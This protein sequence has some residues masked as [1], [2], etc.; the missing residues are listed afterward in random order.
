MRGSSK[1]GFIWRK[2]EISSIN[3]Q[4]LGARKSVRTTLIRAAITLMYAHWEGHVKKAAEVYLTYLN[5]LA[6]NIRE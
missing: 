1:S 4:I 6:L 5:H 3:G 2:H